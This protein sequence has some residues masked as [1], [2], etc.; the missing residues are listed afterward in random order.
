MYFGTSLKLFF[1]I[2]IVTTQVISLPTMDHTS[3]TMP[4]DQHFG[5][6][7]GPSKRSC[8]INYSG[9]DSRLNITR[10]AKRANKNDYTHTAAKRS[11]QQKKQKTGTEI[12]WGTTKSGHK[13]MSTIAQARA[14]VGKVKNKTTSVIYNMLS[15][16]NI[17][18]YMSEMFEVAG[19]AVWR[20]SALV[21]NHY[22]T[23][24]MHMVDIGDGTV[25]DAL[26]AS[27]S[28]LPT[29]ERTEIKPL[30]IKKKM[31]QIIKLKS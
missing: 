2:N 16:M 23:K 9:L 18:R 26:R 1:C 28:V 25:K 31:F 20:L 19:G 10:M 11:Q 8:P 15:V 3:T 21:D 6:S 12:D 14:F 13:V 4:E 30:K 29:E 22:H 17:L 24:H 27:L 7:I 5:P